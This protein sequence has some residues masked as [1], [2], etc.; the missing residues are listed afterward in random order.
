MTKALVCAQ[1][2]DIQGLAP[3]GE[4]TTCHCGACSARWVDAQRGTVSVRARDKTLPRILGLNNRFF[5]QAVEGFTHHEMVAAGGEWEAWRKLHAEST[6]AKGYIFD[7]EFRACWA[8]IIK[9]GE[10]GDVT[11]EPEGS[12]PL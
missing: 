4:W 2:L 11:W 6:D 10:T 8:C 5:V 1:C 7:K 9:V 3:H 12:A